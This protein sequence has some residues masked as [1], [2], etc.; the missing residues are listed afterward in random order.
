MTDILYYT[1]GACSMA[2]HIALREAGADFELRKIDLRSGEQRT[3]EYLAINPKGVTP[4]LKTDKGILTENPVIIGY[5]AQ[6]HPDKKLAPN[7]DSY[8]FG[9]MQAFNIYLGGSVHPAL[10]K[11]LFSRPPLEG[12]ARTD[13]HDLAVARLRMVEDNLFKGPWA[14]GD[15][16]TV[17]D[18]YLYVFERW[19]KQAG[20]LG[21][22][23]K[24]SD[25]LDRVQQR[26][27][28]QEVLRQEG[29]E[30]V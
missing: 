9:A 21:D 16:Y 18:G 3:P 26:P 27:A 20:L 7:D 13:A 12:Q 5:V 23:P 2:S 30:P 17:A 6:E 22:F 1:P 10:G 4:A 25:H 11:L 28:V 8:A 24:L 29:L 15:S 14:T 19:A